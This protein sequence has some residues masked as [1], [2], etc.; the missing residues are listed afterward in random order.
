MPAQTKSLMPAMTATMS[1]R[2]MLSLLALAEVSAMKMGGPDAPFPH[3]PPAPANTNRLRG[4]AETTPAGSTHGEVSTNTEE[5][6]HFRKPALSQVT[7]AMKTG[8]P[9]SP[10]FHGPPASLTA[11]AIQALSAAE[12]TG[13]LNEELDADLNDDLKEVNGDPAGQKP[14]VQLEL[15]ASLIPKNG[16]DKNSSWTNYDEAANRAEDEE[17]KGSYET[18]GDDPEDGLLLKD[19]D[20]AP[21][22]YTAEATRSMIEQASQAFKGLDKATQHQTNM[23]AYEQVR[24]LIQDAKN[25]MT[26]AGVSDDEKLKNST[27]A[28]AYLEAQMAR[29]DVEQLF[30]SGVVLGM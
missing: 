6:V 5:A 10:V 4:V 17:A 23:E 15:F 16:L 1:F 27:Y 30:S 8:S 26:V 18:E 28:D 20:P 9:N 12:E 22:E 7:S 25:D 2:I 14:G 19:Q 13:S 3:G 21:K 29:R 24:D 11:P